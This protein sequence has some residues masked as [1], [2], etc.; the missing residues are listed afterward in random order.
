MVTVEE[1]EHEVRESVENGRL[2]CYGSCC[3]ELQTRGTASPARP[4]S[5]TRKV[6]GSGHRGPEREAGERAYVY[7]NIAATLLHHLQVW[8]M[9]KADRM[10]E[11][12]DELVNAQEC[13]QCALRFVEDA[14]LQHWSMELLAAEKLLFSPQ[15]FF[16]TSDYSVMRHALSVAKSTESAAM[17][18]V[19]CTW[20]NMFRQ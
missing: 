9:L 16:S 8:L 7:L 11:A 10:E 6:S 15:I 4:Y 3:D 13:L 2:I 5:E 12:W 18:P 19:G 20:D 17:W 14:M 1:M